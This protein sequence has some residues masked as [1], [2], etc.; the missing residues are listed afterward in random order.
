MALLPRATTALAV[1]QAAIIGASTA[2]TTVNCCL[3]GILG[4]NFGP[5]FMD[6]TQIDNPIARGCA[7]GGG[8][9]AVGAAALATSDPASFPFGA[10]GM[11][12]TSTFGT[13]L[14]TIPQFTEIVLKVM[15]Q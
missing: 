14:F 13:L 10:L 8:G 2:L 1:V 9:L 6:A 12:L 3:A 7:T 15:G 5:A 11:S 4:A